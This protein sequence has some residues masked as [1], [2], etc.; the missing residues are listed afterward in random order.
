M[1]LEMLAWVAP[2][3]CI[4]QHVKERCAQGRK[5]SRTEGSS[6]DPVAQWSASAEAGPVLEATSEGLREQGPGGPEPL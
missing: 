3:V 5:E 2:S 6:S 4:S 1:K